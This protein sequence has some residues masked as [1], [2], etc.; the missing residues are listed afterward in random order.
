MFFWYGFGACVIFGRELLVLLCVFWVFLC[1]GVMGCVVFW[2]WLG[3]LCWLCGG[4]LVGLGWVGFGCCEFWEL[5]V[6]WVVVGF[7]CFLVLWGWFLFV[8]SW[9][10]FFWIVGFLVWCSFG[11]IGAFGVCGCVVGCVEVCFVRFLFILVCGFVWLFCCFVFFCLFVLVGVGFCGC[12]L[13]W[14]L[15]M[16]DVVLVLLFFMVYFGGF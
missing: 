10:V 6:F 14:C 7:G 5:W 3:W 2:W 8:G 15:F 4:G 1:V 9:F 11:G 12:G 13:V 16:V